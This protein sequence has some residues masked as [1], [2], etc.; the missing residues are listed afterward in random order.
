MKKDDDDENYDSDKE[1]VWKDDDYIRLIKDIIF[2]EWEE[3]VFKDISFLIVLV[4]NRY[5]RLVF[6]Y[7]CLCYLV[8]WKICCIIVLF[9]K[10]MN[11]FGFIFCYGLYC[12]ILFIFF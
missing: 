1:I 3:M 7:C 4:Y 11:M 10:S 8:M 12:F 9:L 5:K 2:V 6:L